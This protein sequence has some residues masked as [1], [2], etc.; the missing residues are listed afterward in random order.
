MPQFKLLSKILPFEDKAFEAFYKTMLIDVR[1]SVFFENEEQIRSLLEK[2]KAHFHASLSMHR[3]DLKKSYIKLGEYHYDLRIPYVDFIKGTNIL[4]EYFLIHSQEETS[5]VDLME[6]IFNY[7]KIMKS[8]TA[9]GYLNRMLEEDKKDIDS[10]F[11]QTANHDDTYLPKSIISEKITWLKEMLHAIENDL[12]FSVDEGQSLLKDWLSEMSFLSLEKREFFENLEER[13]IIN[14]QNLFY[15]LKKSEY[16][17]I[18][19]LYTSLLSIYKLTLMMNNA[20]TIEYANK[21]IDDMQLDSLTQLFRKDLFEEMLKKEI[22]YAKRNDGYYTSIVYIDLDNFKS[23]NDNFGHYS[24]DKVIE[25]MGKI[26]RKNIRGGD[27]GFR[28]GGDEFAIILRDANKQQAHN[29]C[30]KI[31]VD[32]TSYDF[33]FNENVTFSVGISMGIIDFSKESHEDSSALIKSVDAKLYEAKH[34]GKN[35]ISL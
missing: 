17:E 20:I 35:Q 26:I 8:F 1:L 32:F 9:K 7:F 30:K 22:S 16:L 29:V 15:F 21:I 10:F 19:P 11:E 2:Q 23:V 31:K 33:L 18:L 4:E 24:G 25:K 34:R 5:S 14:T 28:I 3:E 27:I 6:E 13:L 12:D